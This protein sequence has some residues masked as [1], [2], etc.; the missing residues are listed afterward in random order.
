MLLKTTDLKK[1]Y[2]KKEALCGFSYEFGPGIYGLLGPNGAGK[3]TLMG[4]LTQNLERSSGTVTYDEKD[5]ESMG[6]DYR[7]LI[8]Y[9][10][11]QQRLYPGFTLKR[12]LFYI[13]S[14]KGIQKDQ[15]ETEIGRIVKEV[16]L[17][18]V[19]YQKL[20]GFSG[21]MKQR[22]VLAQA[23]LGNPLVLILDEP[24]AGVDPRERV[25]IRNMISKMSEN[26]IVIIATHIVS[27][28]EMISDK[29]LLLDKGRLVVSGSPEEICRNIYGKIFEKTVKSDEFDDVYNRYNVTELKREYDSIR[30]RYIA[31]E[32]DEAAIAVAPGLEDVYMYYFG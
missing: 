26:R 11:Q 10:P 18:D 16:G 15:A 23:M 3:S 24:T 32:G 14:L 6:K 25:R 13:S 28:I 1:N 17:E 12:F 29:I 5:I 4:I 27:D 8:G 22:A 2:G 30:I 21:G 19:M 7:K 31:K 20:G 9:M